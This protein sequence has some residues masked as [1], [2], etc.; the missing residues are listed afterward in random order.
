M[1]CPR[2]D[3][4]RIPTPAN[5]GNL[6]KH[7]E[8]EAVRG[9]YVRVRSEGCGHCPHPLFAHFDAPAN[10]AAQSFTHDES[11]LL[12]ALLHL[13]RTFRGPWSGNAHDQ[14]RGPVAALNDGVSFTGA[15]VTEGIRRHEIL[16]Y[17]QKLGTPERWCWLDAGE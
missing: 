7:A 15:K 6:R 1:L 14:D 4:N 3:S 12:P 5:T 10:K 17:F 13:L 9:L 16:R 11:S 8:S 2:W